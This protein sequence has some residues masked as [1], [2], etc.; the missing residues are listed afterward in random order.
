MSKKEI[1]LVGVDGSKESLNAVKWAASRVKKAD[2]RMHIICA[3]SLPSF[4]PSSL[5]GGYATIDDVSIKEGAQIVVDEAVKLA[6]EEGVEVTS[7]IEVGDPARI[8]VELSNEVSMIVVGK[9]G[10]G[11]GIAD[12]LLGSVS[13][14][15]ACHSCCTVVIVPFADEDKDYSEINEIVVGVDGSESSRLAFKAAIYETKMDNAHLTAVM[16]VPMTNSLGMFTWLPFTVEKEVILED[17][18]N[19]LNEVIETELAGEELE[20][21]RYA[22]EGHPT[23]VLT[24]FSSRSDLLVVGTRGRGGFTGLLLG[25]T[26]QSLLNYSE[27]PIMIVPST[28]EG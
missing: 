2:A 28:Y 24:E 15:L 6:T 27:C 21:T 13:S 7:S 22:L 14:A 20:V 3:Y 16:T 10:T 5:E 9:S 11:G 18:S 26:S 19:S 23:K 17:V 4:T 1:I 8:L 12:R 25:S